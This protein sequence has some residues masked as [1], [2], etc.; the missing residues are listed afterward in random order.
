MVVVTKRQQ[1]CQ[2]G[3]KLNIGPFQLDLVMMRTMR[4]MMVKPEGNDDDDYDDNY[5]A[6]DLLLELPGLKARKPL[7]A[8]SRLGRQMELKID[9]DDDD[10][11]VNADESQL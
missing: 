11:Y 2:K 3:W 1:S 5:H 6:S 8:A 10:E 9:D 4:M 7:I